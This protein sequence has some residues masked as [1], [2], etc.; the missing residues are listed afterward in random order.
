MLTQPSYRTTQIPIF[1]IAHFS[2]FE[3]SAGLKFR[4]NLYF[5]IE[6]PP[7]SVL[8][9]T[10]RGF[11]FKKSW[12]GSWFG[13]GDPPWYIRPGMPASGISHLSEQKR[14]LGESVWVHKRQK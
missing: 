10:S 3:N 4:K 6:S 2:V 13:G 14:G 5:P 1:E 7:I 11:F 12:V 9:R 8:K